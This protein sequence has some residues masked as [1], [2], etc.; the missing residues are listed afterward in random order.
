MDF[1][2]YDNALGRFHNMDRLAELAPGI[3]PYRFAFNNPVYWSDPT[4]LFE[5][6]GAAF[7]YMLQNKTLGTIE[8]S[9]GDNGYYYINVG[10]GIDTQNIMMFDGNLVIGGSMIE[11]VVVSNGGGG[12][13]SGFGF[14]GNGGFDGVSGSGFG[15]WSD[16]DG[17][18][19]NTNY[20]GNAAAIGGFFTT[21][22][23]DRAAYNA[24]Y[25]YKYGTKTVSAAELTVK[26]A[27]QMTKL[28]NVA[29][30]I[31]TKVGVAGIGLTI[32]DDYRNDNLGV[33]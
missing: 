15:G 28:S 1:R 7:S 29:G 30:S 22:L 24:N 32:Y 33:G 3:T 19:I 27:A 18:E 25:I 23:S 13:G 10:T 11:E 2:Q 26:N 9:G 12:S 21:A 20:G 6:W 14:G 17:G 31:S 5:S 4:G 8:Y 16:Y